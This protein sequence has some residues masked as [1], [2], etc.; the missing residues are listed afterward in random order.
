MVEQR[1]HG[2]IEPV[3]LAQLDGE[4]LGQIA[5]AHPRRI[6]ALQPR[7]H[8]LDPR[9]RRPELVGGLHQV[10]GEVASLVD[11]IDQVLGDHP[12]DRIGE[13]ERHLLGEMAGERGLLG[14]EGLE[15][16]VAV[17]AAAGTD[18]G[19]FRIGGRLRLGLARRPRRAL[20]GKHIFEAG[21]EPLLDGL[22]AGLQ[23]IL[24]PIVVAG[25]LVGRWT[26]SWVGS[27]SPRTGS[28]SAGRS[29]SGFF[30]N[31]PSTYAARSRCDSCRS[32]MACISCGVITKAWL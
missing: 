26:A 13:G 11:E 14:D 27:A 28:S 7:Q 4:A 25:L 17:G 9:Q 2:G 22:A 3:E 18:T 23:A 15:I 19:P 21:V 24:H 5:R 31:S 12:V 32:L 6:E 20:V 1:R 30:S 8:R 29:S 16:V 10:A